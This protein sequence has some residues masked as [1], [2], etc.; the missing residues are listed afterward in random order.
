MLRSVQEVEGE[1]KRG[2]GRGR[3]R[4]REIRQERFNL[5]TNWQMTFTE[6]YSPQSKFGI[7]Q[8]RSEREERVRGCPREREKDRERL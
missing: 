2:K 4:E 5:V 1:K 8:C 3:N 6:M 7:G